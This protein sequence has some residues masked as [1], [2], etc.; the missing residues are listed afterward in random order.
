MNRRARRAAARG[1]R[2]TGYL[3]RL[4]TAKRQ[5]VFDQLRGQLVHAVIEHDSWCAIFR[6]SS[7]DCTPN[8]DAED[9]VKRRVV[10]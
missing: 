9:R 6:R 8:V 4:A 5:D 1:I 3:H 2:S 7:W 10:S